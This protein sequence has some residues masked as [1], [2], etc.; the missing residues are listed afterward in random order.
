MRVLLLVIAVQ[1]FPEE[2]L[3]LSEKFL[4]VLPTFY[5]KG[6][7]RCW[8]TCWISPHDLAFSVPSDL[9]SGSPPLSPDFPIITR[10]SSGVFFELLFPCSPRSLGFFPRF[11]QGLIFNFKQ[12]P[13]KSALFLLFN[14]YHYGEGFYWLFPLAIFPH[15]I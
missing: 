3:K 5:E 1:P 11:S 8:K 14:L 2:A 12:R 15:V 13:R 10:S 6:I 9:F 7:Q 4:I